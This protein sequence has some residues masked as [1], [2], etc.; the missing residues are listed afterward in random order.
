MTELIRLRMTNN[1]GTSISLYALCHFPILDM[2]IYDFREQEITL[3]IVAGQSAHILPG[4]MFL[5]KTKEIPIKKEQNA[6]VKLV[7]GHDC[8]AFYLESLTVLLYFY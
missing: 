6:G 2:K 3:S 8:G 1:L 7:L 4:L 5:T